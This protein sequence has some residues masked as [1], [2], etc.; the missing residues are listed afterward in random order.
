[1][2]RDELLLELAVARQVI[3]DKVALLPREALRED[4]PGFDHSV[5]QL[6]S[7]LA[8]YDRLVVNRLESA[9]HGAMTQLAADQDPDAYEAGSWNDMD[10]WRVE[11]VLRRSRANFETVVS[12]LREVADDEL[13]GRIGAGGALDTRWLR[14]RAPWR[15]IYDDTAGHYREHEQL[16][17]AARVVAA[18]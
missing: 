18:Q 17:D 2:T 3:D 12:R 1:V 4:V 9:G 5:L 6:L 10:S 7:H 8:A 14:G 15:A 13:A 16:L 11:Q